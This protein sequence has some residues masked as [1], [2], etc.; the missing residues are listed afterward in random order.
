MS[1]TCEYNDTSRG[2][3]YIISLPGLVNGLGLFFQRCR[4]KSTLQTGLSGLQTKILSYI[5]SHPGPVHGSAA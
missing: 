3:K 5:G 1:P 4:G 2:W